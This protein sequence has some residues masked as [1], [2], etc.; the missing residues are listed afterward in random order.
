MHQ[1]FK[2]F[3]TAQLC[4]H[5]KTPEQHQEHVKK[6]LGE[7]PVLPSLEQNKITKRL[8][9]IVEESRLNSVAAGIINNNKNIYI[10]PIL[11][12]AKCFTMLQKRVKK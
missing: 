9:V 5:K 1:S 2:S 6:V 8:S 3:Q 12:S 10:A 11:S 4:G 7:V